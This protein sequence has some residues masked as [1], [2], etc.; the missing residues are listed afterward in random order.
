MK[1][2][3]VPRKEKHEVEIV[4]KLIMS[5]TAEMVVNIFVE[6]AEAS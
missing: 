1:A 4:A 2:F 3:K 6:M 5:K